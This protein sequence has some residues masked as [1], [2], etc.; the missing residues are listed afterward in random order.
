MKRGHIMQESTQWAIFV[1]MNTDYNRTRAL[2]YVCLGAIFIG[3]SFKSPLPWVH[4]TTSAIWHTACVLTVHICDHCWNELS[5]TLVKISLHG[6][7]RYWHGNQGYGRDVGCL[8][9][10]WWLYL[11]ILL[12]LL[13]HIFAPFV[14]NLLACYLYF[15][16]DPTSLLIQVF[17]FLMLSQLIRRAF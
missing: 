5:H 17:E 14:F 6:K 16:Q 1:A 13:V 12:G 7:Q 15:Q 8:I 4:C 11:C 10:W 3:H 2:C 9:G